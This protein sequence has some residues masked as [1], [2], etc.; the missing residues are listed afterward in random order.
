MIIIGLTIYFAVVSVFVAALAFAA[1]RPIPEVENI[2]VLG[3]PL[4][5]NDSDAIAA[6]LKKAA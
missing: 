6:I 4:S 2:E 1:S 3:Q 5:E